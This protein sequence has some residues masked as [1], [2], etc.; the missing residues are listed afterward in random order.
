MARTVACIQSISVYGQIRIHFLSF[1]FGVWVLCKK[2][3]K[4]VWN[5]KGYGMLHLRD[6][7]PAFLVDSSLGQHKH[8]KLKVII[9]INQLILALKT[10]QNT[11]IIIINT[12]ENTYIIYYN[13]HYCFDYH[14]FVLH[15]FICCS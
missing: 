3:V 1:V 9:L 6:T 5:P 15:I 14:I 2:L 4:W 8:V 13:K 10:M 7:P 12:H 11:L